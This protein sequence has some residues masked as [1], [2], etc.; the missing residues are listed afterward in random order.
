MFLA[1]K[2][3]ARTAEGRWMRNPVWPS[4]CVTPA[5]TSNELGVQ[6]K[7][8]ENT[9]THTHTHFK[10]RGIS[11]C[12]ADK[13]PRRGLHSI[14]DTTETWRGGGGCGVKFLEISSNL[15]LELPALEMFRWGCSDPSRIRHTPMTKNG[16]SRPE[17]PR[18]SV[19]PDDGVKKRYK[20]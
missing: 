14:R 10:R 2:I 20:A 11:I 7:W 1:R 5:G 12:C 8:E 15:F 18:K 9:H 6:N 13:V 17:K 19:P 3:K 16:T 4:S